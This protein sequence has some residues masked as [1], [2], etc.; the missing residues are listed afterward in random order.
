MLLEDVLL[1]EAIAL[2]NS[3]E[4]EVEELQSDVDSASACGI[5]GYGKN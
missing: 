3:K 2:V 4:A 5:C 1:L